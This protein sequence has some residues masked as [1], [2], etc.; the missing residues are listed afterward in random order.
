MKHALELVSY[1]YGAGEVTRETRHRSGAH[2]L[3]RSQKAR[4]ETS[5]RERH[6]MGGSVSIDFEVHLRANGD[7][8]AGRPHGGYEIGSY[9]NLSARGDQREKA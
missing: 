4:Y 8:E 3:D 9:K 5:S 7:C 1:I 2:D 6:A